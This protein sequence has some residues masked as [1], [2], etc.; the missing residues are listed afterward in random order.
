MRFPRTWTFCGGQPGNLV[1]NYIYNWP[2]SQW[3]TRLKFNLQGFGYF[4][5]GVFDANPN[6]LECAGSQLFR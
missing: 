4:Q 3:A 5:V 2:V 6:Y 1:G